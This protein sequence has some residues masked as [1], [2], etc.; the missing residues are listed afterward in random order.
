MIGGHS[1][2]RHKEQQLRSEIRRLEAEL[3]KHRWIPVSERLPTELGHTGA[4][5]FV[6]VSGHGEVF[7]AVY[8]HDEKMWQSWDSGWDEEIEITHWREITL[9]GDSK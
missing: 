9:P 1:D 4:T 5:W 6:H 7:R 2:C 8:L 3:E